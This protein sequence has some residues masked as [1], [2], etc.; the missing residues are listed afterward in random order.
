MDTCRTRSLPE[1]AS[2]QMVASV[3]APPSGLVPRK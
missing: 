1:M 3:P 2:G